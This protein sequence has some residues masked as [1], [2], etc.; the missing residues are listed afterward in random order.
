MRNQIVKA[1]KAFAKGAFGVGL[2]QA[3][4]ATPQKPVVAP[5]YLCSDDLSG[6]TATLPKA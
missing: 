4:T 1:A 3:Q 6:S 5:D 2:I